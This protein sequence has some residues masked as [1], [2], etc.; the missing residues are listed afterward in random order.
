VYETPGGAILHFGAPAKSKSLTMDR[1]SDA[2]TRTVLI[3]KYAELVYNG[4]WY[5]PERLA[6]PGACHREPEERLRARC[7]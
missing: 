4:F 6:H 3:P 2:S 5:A 7:V 1:E